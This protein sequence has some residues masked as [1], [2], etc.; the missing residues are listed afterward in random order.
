VAYGALDHGSWRVMADNAQSKKYPAIVG[1]SVC[2]SPD[3][4]HLA[5]AVWNGSQ[6]LLVLDGVEGSEYE[7]VGE[8]AFESANLLRAVA[9]H[10]G[11]VIRLEIDVPATA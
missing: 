1:N 9:L 2:F 10:K 4:K 8:V 5:Y 6:H 11:E 3:S 7:G